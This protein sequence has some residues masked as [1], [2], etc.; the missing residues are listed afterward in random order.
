MNLTP[1]RKGDN[2]ATDWRKVNDLITVVETLRSE[3]R[4]LSGAATD[5]RN[6]KPYLSAGGGGAKVSQFIITAI[7]DDS[8]TCHTYLDE[9]EGST[10]I[11]VLKPYLLRRSAFDSISRT[12][13][14]TENLDAITIA[15]SYTA[16]QERDADSAVYSDHQ[17]VTP[18]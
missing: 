10:D 1:I 11:E 4:R 16:A 5:L 9:V 3:V 8:L 6:R 13:P 14:A 12:I 17:V 7:G 18:R 2:P 15:Y